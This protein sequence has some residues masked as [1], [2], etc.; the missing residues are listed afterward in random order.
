MLPRVITFNIPRRE[1]NAPYCLNHRYRFQLPL[2]LAQQYNII[3]VPIIVQFG[4]ESYRN[5]YDIN[6][7]AI[8]ARV[9]REGKLP[10]SA[11]PAPEILLMLTERLLRQARI[12]SFA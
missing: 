10:T 7:A 12:K 4:E 5:V 11:A 3:E 9:D 6:N 1:Q 8:F 2:D